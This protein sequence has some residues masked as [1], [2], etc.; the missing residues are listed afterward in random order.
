MHPGMQSGYQHKKMIF[1]ER[2]NDRENLKLAK[3][4]FKTNIGLDPKDYRI[5]MTNIKK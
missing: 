4:W 2:A 1:R 3:Q 5:L